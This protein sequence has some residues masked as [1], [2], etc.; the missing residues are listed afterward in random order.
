MPEIWL[1]YGITDVVLDIQAENLDQEIST[2]T[3]TLDD[4][5][6]NSRLDS[7]DLTKPLE[8]VVLNNSKSVHQAISAI[9]VKCEQKSIRMPKILADV[10]ILPNL[11]KG[12]PEGC[13][14]VEFGAAE[15]TNPNLA[16]IGE[17]E[18]DGLFGFESIATRLLRRFSTENMLSAYEKRKGSLPTPGEIV[19]N[20]SIAKDFVDKFEIFSIEIA[21]NS[22]G[23]IDLAIGHPSSTM[24]IS[25]SFLQSATKEVSKHRT[26]IISTGK[27]SS[28]DSLG[29]SL[30]S[31]WNCYECIKNDGL[32]ILL[33]ES[34]HGIGSNAIQHF[35][36][37]QMSLDRLKKPSKYISG[38]EDLL[39][40]TEIQKK[41]EIGLSS[42]LPEFYLKKL[43]IT[44]FSGTKNAM[45]YILKKQGTRQKV[46]I[47]SDGARILLKEANG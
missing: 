39:Y 17:M 11:K 6:I 22:N 3:K 44:S 36:E 46:A 10:K 21:A 35:I 15:L 26:M 41:F 25:K 38:M 13:S 9:F 2:D 40:L 43:N 20:V 7:V 1:N 24:S 34:T 27:D 12:L 45:D 47:V 16:F 4:S 37:G 5:E 19:D 29:K 28:N 42:I 31:L 23:I 14:V 18:F 8:L 32:A 30:S 33:A